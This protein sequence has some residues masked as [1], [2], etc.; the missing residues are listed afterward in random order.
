MR[1]AFK[2][3]LIIGQGNFKKNQEI[4]ELGEITLGSLPGRWHFI[5]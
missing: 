2:N 4:L 5:Y 3:K 1:I